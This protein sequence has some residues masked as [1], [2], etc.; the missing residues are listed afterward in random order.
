MVT[1]EFEYKRSNKHPLE[2]VLD[3]GYVEME[4]NKGDIIYIIEKLD[5]VFVKFF[6]I[7]SRYKKYKSIFPFKSLL[8]KH[9]KSNC[10]K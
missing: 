2:D 4:F 5:K 1:K 7:K 8:Y 9:F 10:I 6:G 3:V